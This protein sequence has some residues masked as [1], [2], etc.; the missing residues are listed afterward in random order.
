MKPAPFLYLAPDSLEAAVEAMHEHGDEA[1]LLAGGQSLIASMNFRCLTPA[2]LVD[3]NAL[4]EL[5]FHSH[6]G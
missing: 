5:E 2:F 4:P 6:R 3:L 1:R